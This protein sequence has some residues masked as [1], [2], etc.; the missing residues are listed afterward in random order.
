MSYYINEKTNIQG[1]TVYLTRDDE[2]AEIRIMKTQGDEE[3]TDEE[4]E[5]ILLEY[6]EDLSEVFDEVFGNKY[7]EENYEAE[8]EELV[9]FHRNF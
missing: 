5:R 9:R 3:L 2:V 4:I 8:A 1:R 7:N 6:E